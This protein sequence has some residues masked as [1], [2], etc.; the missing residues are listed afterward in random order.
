MHTHTHTHHRWS[1]S[2]DLL[3]QLLQNSSTRTLQETRSRCVALKL[4]KSEG[5][6]V[7]RHGTKALSTVTGK[8]RRKRQWG[9]EK[10]SKKGMR[11]QSEAKVRWGGEGS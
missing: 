9:V 11:E 4:G 1:D 6:G 10:K 3:G 2:K 7:T 5:Y 8:C